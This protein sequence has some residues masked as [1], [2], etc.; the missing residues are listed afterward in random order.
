[1]N[2]DDNIDNPKAAGG[3]F[4]DALTWLR[5]LLMPLVVFLIWKG[6][7]PDE[8]GG[9]DLSLT[10]LASALF[11]VAALTDIFDDFLGGGERSVHRRFGYLDDIAD[12]VLVVGTIAAILYVVNRS[13]YLS[14]TL[15]VP[16]AILIGR[17]IVLGLLKGFEMARFIVPDTLLSNLKSGVSMLGT[18]LLLG[19]P[20]LQALLDRMLAGTDMAAQTYATGTPMVW[21]AG[22]ICLWLAAILSIIT[23]VQLFRTDFSDANDA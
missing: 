4:A 5:M 10:L 16:A 21:N 8:K 14:W 15:L 2:S 13:G 3:A 22:V 1:M 7:Q 17:E 12:T 23:A 20:W 6:W 11:I 19:F 9:I 18:C